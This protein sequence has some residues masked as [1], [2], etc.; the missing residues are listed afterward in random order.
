MAQEPWE[1]QYFPV[2][3]SLSAPLPR[4]KNYMI[5]RVPTVENV[6]D[7]DKSD[8]EYRD[9]PGFGNS[10]VV[11]SIAIRRDFEPE[12]EMF[13]DRFFSNYVF[14]TDK[15]AVRILQRRCTGMRFVDAPRKRKTLR[16]RSLRGIEEEGLDPD[17]EVSPPRLVQAI[18]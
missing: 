5:M 14:C 9:I 12:H 17:Q 10:L 7:L 3:A 13:R 4:S 16:F 11:R 2:D 8:Y 6:A 18:D 1:A 15:F